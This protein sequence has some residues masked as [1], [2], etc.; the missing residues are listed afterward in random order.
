M[1]DELLK[2][3]TNPL[4]NILILEVHEQ[5]QATAKTL[6]QK[7]PNIPQATLYR[8]LKKMTSDGVLKVVEERPIRNVTE[9]VYA[10]AIDLDDG[11]EQMLADNCGETYFSLFQQFS[12]GLLGEFKAYADQGEVDLV[13]DG[14][15]FR[16]TPFYATYDELKE[17]SAKIHEVIQPYKDAEPT[18][19]RKARSV[20]VVFTPPRPD[21]DMGGTE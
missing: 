14:S 9:K 5:V 16:V 10:L 7:H 12:I 19:K 4:A 18:P 17:L 3:L 6:A 13:G 20:A 21:G 1:T 11:V 2:Y 8:Y 15:G